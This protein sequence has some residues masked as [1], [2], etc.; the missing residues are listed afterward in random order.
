MNAILHLDLDTF[1]VSVERLKNSKLIGKPVLIG[2]TSDRGV[3]ASCSYEARQFGIHSAMPMKLA[4]SLCPE[5]IIVRGNSADYTKHSRIVTDIL[6]ESVPVLEKSS[7]DEFYVDLTGMDK[8]HGTWKLANELRSKITE[9]SG[10]PISFG[11]SE[12]KTVSKVATNEAKPNNQMRIEYGHEKAFLAP[13]SVKK[14]PM[15]GDKTYAKLVSLGVRK[16]HT[17]QEMPIDLMQRAFGANGATIWRKANGIDQSKV[18]PYSERKSISTERTFDRDTID[19]TKLKG[20]LTAMTENLAFQL[21]RGEKLTACLTVKVRYSDFNTYTLQSR[22]PY[23]AA[24]H[25]LIPK[26]LEMFDKLYNKRLLVR[27]IGVRMSDLVNGFHQIDLFDDSEEQLNLYHAMD[28]IRDKYGDRSVMRAS[29]IQAR[30]IGR[31]NPFTGEP[32]PLLANR[33]Q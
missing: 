25:V 27:L 5:A 28:F 14:I 31:W 1:F 7:I 18:I 9:N 26:A 3:V 12:N 24:D 32:P 29:G 30:T 13:L 33:R 23:T 19:V 8:F 21:R 6:Q 15:V 4:R 20:I 11:L 16:I 10:L 22:V 17:I 2:G